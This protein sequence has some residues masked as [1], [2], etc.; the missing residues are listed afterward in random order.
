MALIHTSEKSCDEWDDEYL[1]EIL[2][3]GYELWL[4]RR[5]LG[6][7]L[8]RAEDVLGI[9]E[10]GDDYVRLDLSHQTLSNFQAQGNKHDLKIVLENWADG[11]RQSSPAAIPHESYT[12]LLLIHQGLLCCRC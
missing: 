4:E 11:V 1:N 10:V 12:D 7:D 2:D 5:Q 8:L 3:K 9:Y 6:N